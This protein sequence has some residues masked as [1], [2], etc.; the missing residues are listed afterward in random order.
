M[1]LDCAKLHTVNSMFASYQ[2]NHQLDTLS[3]LTVRRR[4]AIQRGA[5]YMGR[6]IIRKAKTFLNS[7]VAG[8]TLWRVSQVRPASLAI[9]TSW[10]TSST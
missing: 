5:R 2:M 6:Y 3:P 4:T 8:P 1:V 9:C 10:Y 7:R